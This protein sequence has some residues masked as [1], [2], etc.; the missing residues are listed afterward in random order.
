MTTP[1]DPFLTVSL[2]FSVCDCVAGLEGSAYT[3]LL[4]SMVLCSFLHA[5]SII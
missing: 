5:L 1:V 4:G 3:L 2:L